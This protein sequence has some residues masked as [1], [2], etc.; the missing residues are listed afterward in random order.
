MLNRK[1]IIEN[2]DRLDAAIARRRRIAA[3]RGNAESAE[4]YTRDANELQAVRD[5]VARGQWA[6]AGRL[7]S[8]LDLLVRGFI[9]APLLTAAASPAAPSSPAVVEDLGP[10]QDL[11]AALRENLRPDGIVAIAAFLQVGLGRTN[12]DVVNQQIRWFHDLLVGLVG[13]DEFNR[14]SEQLGL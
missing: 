2:L 13:T 14:V 5:A 10:K 11:Q 9:P 12:D 3:N 7:I 6:E 4:R 1:A 8:Q